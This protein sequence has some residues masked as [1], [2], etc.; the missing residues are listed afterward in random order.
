MTTGT[1]VQ[2]VEKFGESD[3]EE[4][5]ES[6]NLAILDGG[7]F[8]WLEPPPRQTLEAYWRG[9]CWSRNASYLWHV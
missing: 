2:M 5:C 4:L 3:V 1:N 7:G 6:A 9:S 8:G